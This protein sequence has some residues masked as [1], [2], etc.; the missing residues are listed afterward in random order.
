[1]GAGAHE[2]HADGCAAVLGE[3]TR[4]GKTCAK[5]PGRRVWCAKGDGTAGAEGTR[6]EKEEELGSPTGVWE[7]VELTRVI[8]THAAP[9][10]PSVSLW[11]VPP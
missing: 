4:A 9:E 3:T 10:I 1:M 2:E 7:P 6:S 11:W 8:S 5:A